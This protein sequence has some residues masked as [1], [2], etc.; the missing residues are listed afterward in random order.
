MNL[1]ISVIIPVYNAEKYLKKCI[2]SVLNQTFTNFEL[3]LINDGS[4]DNSGAICDK[5][6]EKDSR[7]MVFHQENKGVSSARNLGLDNAKG[8]WICFVDSDD[9]VEENYLNDLII[10][11]EPNIDFVI[12]GFTQ[13]IN[14]TT[15]D[16]SL[17]DVNLIVNS[18][19]KELILN[20]FALFN[21]SYPFAKLYRSEIINRNL[22]RFLTKAIMFEDTIFLMEYLKHSNFIKLINSKD[23]QYILNEGSLSFKLHSFEAEYIVAE[24]LLDI[25]T[26]DFDLNAKDLKSKYSKLGKRI[27]T[28]TNRAILSMLRNP[29]SKIEVLKK[30]K[31]IDKKCIKLYSYFYTPN[32]FFRKIIK[33]L[34]VNEYYILCY[35]YSKI[36]YTV[37]SLISSRKI[38]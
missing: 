31:L 18:Q 15:K 7:V 20:K 14:T 21:Y 36:V 32:N 8:E 2:D 25:A 3:L 35:Y 13:R 28:S 6:A 9:W 33:F 24:K 16:Q 23:Y 30:I 27:S 38:A 22:I 10:S 4:H 5:Y 17:T 29:E 26:N 34:V 12:G 19:N 37:S 1:V 11:I